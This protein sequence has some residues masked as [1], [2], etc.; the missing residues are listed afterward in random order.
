MM[1]MRWILVGTAAQVNKYFIFTLHRACP[2]G[3]DGGVEGEEEEEDGWMG[4]RERRRQGGEVSGR[5]KKQVL[6]LWR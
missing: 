2:S 1:E 3:G 5:E 6:C 4:V